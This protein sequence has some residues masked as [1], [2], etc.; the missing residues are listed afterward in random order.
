[1][2]IGNLPAL[3]AGALLACASSAGA[4]TYATDVIS[5]VEGAG[6]G[7]PGRDDPTA[8]LGAE[9]DSFYSLGLGGEIVLGFDTEFTGPGTAWE[10][11]FGNA[12]SHAEAIAIAVG[13]DGVFTDVGVVTNID[14]SGVTGASFAFDGVFNQL[15]VTD[16]TL[17]E[18]SSS[19][20]TDGFDLNAV[21]VT[22][23]GV[24]PIP[25]SVLLL[26]AAVGG[27]AVARR[28]RS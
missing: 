20:S 1:M 5:V 27:L 6:A 12:A 11:T 16:V 26:G 23:L 13:N 18:F 22:E 10:V 3:V 17:I 4:I 9:D 15:R 21:G 19:P 8:T 25:A 28:A 2:N 14:A 24:V 7:T